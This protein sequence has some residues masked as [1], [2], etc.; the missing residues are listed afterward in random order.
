MNTGDSEIE[1]VDVLVIGGGI[2]GAGVTQAA[3]AAG[4]SVLLVELNS[5]ASATSSNSTK[6][7][8]GGL[9][10]LES[11]QLGLVY[12]SL[13]ERELLLQLAPDLVR[14]EWFYIPVYQ[15]N[16]RPAW[17][18][19]L[20]LLLYWALSLGRSRCKSIPRKQWRRLIPGLN[21]DRMTA[22]LAYED[23][24]TDDAALTQSVATSAEQMGADILQH[25]AF[26]S[27]QREG[28]YWLVKLDPER[29]VR[30]KILIN[31]GGPWVNR[32]RQH[33]SP[34]PPVQQVHLV[35]GAH[36]YLDRPCPAFIYVESED[37]RVMFFRPWRQGTLA[38]TTETVFTGDPATVHASEDEVAAILATYN[39]YFPESACSESDILKRYCGIRVLPQKE[40]PQNVMPQEELQQKQSPASLANVFSASRDTQLLCDH[41]KNPA[42]IAIY[43][44]KLTTY[45]KESEK[46]ARLISRSLPE[47]RKANTR[48]IKLS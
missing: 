41:E 44:G 13:H 46:V 23:A 18:V 34:V 25:T 1:E 3:A 40:L 47:A 45:R 38:G 36:L 4:H 26:V 14:R 22:L 31:A 30:A 17:L 20:G 37:G 6:L 16:K 12:E 21:T 32:I 28:D 35:Q 27:A 43:G 48:D 39:R 42:Y 33:I 19:K 9:R 10:Y 24:A 2:Y 7:I 8:H 15:Y 29:E 5:I 11:M